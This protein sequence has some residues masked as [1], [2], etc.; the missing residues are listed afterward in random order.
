MLKVSIA[1]AMH[2]GAVWR[3]LL[4]E[5]QSSAPDGSLEPLALQL[6]HGWEGWEQGASELVIS[7][8]AI[9]GSFKV[10]WMVS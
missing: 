3:H 9:G 1:R 2:S 6:A 10:W 4:L 8:A 7:G 5:E